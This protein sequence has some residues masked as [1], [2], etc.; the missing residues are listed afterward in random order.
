MA[1]R[2]AAMAPS[3]PVHD[4]TGQLG[5]GQHHRCL[6]HTNR[7]GRPKQG[8]STNSTTGQSFTQARVAHDEH[9]GGATRCSM[10]TRIG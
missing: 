9:V 5:L 4:P 2:A 7:A 1:T 8:R 6:R 10:W 3:S